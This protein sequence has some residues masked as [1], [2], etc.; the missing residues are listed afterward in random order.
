MLYAKN[1]L[2]LLVFWHL[3]NGTGNRVP[4]RSGSGAEQHGWS[5]YKLG[6]AYQ[7]GQWCWR[8][9]NAIASLPPL[10]NQQEKS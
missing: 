3:D 1:V 4:V 5:K 8:A 2:S 10:F 7:C 9:F 6:S